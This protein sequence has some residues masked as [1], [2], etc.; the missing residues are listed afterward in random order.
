MYSSC[1]WSVTVL[2]NCTKLK[3]HDESQCQFYLVSQHMNDAI[4]VNSQFWPHFQN[5]LLYICLEIEFVLVIIPFLVMQ[6]HIWIYMDRYV[7]LFKFSC[8]LLRS[9]LSW[10]LTTVSVVRICVYVVAQ[11]YYTSIL[12]HFDISSISFL[13]KC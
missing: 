8:E 7:Y 5:W 4:N 11:N 1:T 3:Q 6:F 13:A 10:L 2:L 9:C 12:H